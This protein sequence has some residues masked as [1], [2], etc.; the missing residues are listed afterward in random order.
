M[1]NRTQCQR[2]EF[3]EEHEQREQRRQ[4]LLQLQQ[5]EQQQA[6]LQEKIAAAQQTKE[7]L[8]TGRGPSNPG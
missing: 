8:S 4:T 7:R 6:A 2:D 5:I 3:M 1:T